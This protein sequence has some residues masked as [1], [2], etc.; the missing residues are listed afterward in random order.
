MRFLFPNILVFSRCFFY[1]QLYV[2]LK[3]KIQ[4]LHEIDWEDVAQFTITTYYNRES[5]EIFQTYLAIYLWQQIQEEKRQTDKQQVGSTFCGK[6]IW[7][8][9]N[10]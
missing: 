2:I 10:L 9:A 5:L 1:I 8:D 6:V 4:H 3:Y 7:C